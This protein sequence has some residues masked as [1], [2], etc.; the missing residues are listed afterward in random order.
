LPELLDTRERDGVVEILIETTSEGG[1]TWE[2]LATFSVRYQQLR[3]GDN[4]WPLSLEEALRIAGWLAPDDPL[5]VCANWCDRV[6]QFGRRVCLLRYG[7]DGPHH[8]GSF[9]WEAEL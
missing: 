2:S 7:H 8:D 4:H 3:Q 1:E 9:T 5:P 6:P